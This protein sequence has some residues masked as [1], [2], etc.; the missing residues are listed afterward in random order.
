MHEKLHQFKDRHYTAQS[1]TLVVQS[2]N[3]METIENL[4]VDIFSKVPNNSLQKETFGHLEKP[5]GTPGF[6]KLYKVAPLQ[7]VYQL[8]LIWSLPP[9]V[10]F[11]PH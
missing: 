8:E 6:H 10:S 7:N 4:V 5:F 1:M 2:Q 3:T 11:S 9:M